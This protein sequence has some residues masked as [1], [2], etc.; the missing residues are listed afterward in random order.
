M[1]RK[2]FERID[3]EMQVEGSTKAVIPGFSVLR[4]FR[5][6]GVS[7]ESTTFLHSHGNMIKEIRVYKRTGFLWLRKETLFFGRRYLWLDKP[8][9]L[10]ILRYIPGEWELQIS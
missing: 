8:S 9:E 7:F 2:M 4:Q 5:K 1:S 3:S 10:E 6:S